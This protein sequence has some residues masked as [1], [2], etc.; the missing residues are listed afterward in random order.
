MKKIL[1]LIDRKLE[2]FMIVGLMTILVCGLVY[3]AFVR[4]FVTIPALTRFTYI[5]EEASIFS[6]IWLIYFGAALAARD[7]A[8]FRVSAQFS[9]LPERL[10]PWR[11]LLADIVWVLFN[12]FVVY[13]GYELVRITTTR[14]ENSLALG[15]PMWIVYLII[16]LSF[17]LTSWRVVQRYIRGEH[18]NDTEKAAAV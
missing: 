12:L 5:S 10:K 15:I 2:E 4:Y 6:F 16:P 8:H 14:T 9:R 13:Q 18:F 7:G 1:T 17:L 11:F 3:S